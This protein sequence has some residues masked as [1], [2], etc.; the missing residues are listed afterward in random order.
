MIS[1]SLVRLLL[2]LIIIPFLFTL[3][4]K[5]GDV[6]TNFTISPPPLG[7]PEFSD[8]LVITHQGKALFGTI[9]G[10]GIDLYGVSA[11]WIPRVSTGYVAADL[12][13]GFHTMMGTIETGNGSTDMNFFGFD[14]APNAELLV[15]NLS[16]FKLIFAA[17]Y[18]LSNNRSAYMIEDFTFDTINYYDVTVYINT[19]MYG[20][21]FTIQGSIM[22]GTDFMFSPYVV[23]ASISGTTNTHADPNFEFFN[24]SYDVPAFRTM[25]YGF[26]VLY[27]P[28][29]LTLSG[30]LQLLDKSGDRGEVRITSFGAGIK[31]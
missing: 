23:F 4:A 7:Y 13:V 1:K 18:S 28:G 8:E 3:Q 17:G 10:D 26:D 20:P 15:I 30:M 25:T 12:L 27:V 21:V 11:A 22:M 16:G 29:G 31:F 2:T 9:S 5:A 6:Q 14:L 19:L 24:T